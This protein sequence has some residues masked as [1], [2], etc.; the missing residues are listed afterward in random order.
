MKKEIKMPC[1]RGAWR[2][3]K[4]RVRRKATYGNRYFFT[5][6]DS[7]EQNQE[8]TECQLEWSVIHFFV[9]P[10]NYSSKKT[11]FYFSFQGD[12]GGAEEPR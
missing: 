7:W 2:K 12:G 3:L 6:N 5:V 10:L 4:I 1:W 8:H 11:Y 9:L